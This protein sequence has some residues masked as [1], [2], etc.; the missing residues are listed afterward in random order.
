M[1]AGNTGCHEAFGSRGDA[2][3]DLLVC[4]DM[5]DRQIGVED[6]LACHEQG[7]LHRAFSVVLWR[8]GKE[9]AEI[10]LQQRAQGKYHSGGLWANAC[11]SHPRAG[12]ELSSAVRR[13]LS[14]ELGI[15]GVECQEIGSFVYY[16]PFGNGLS[17]YEYDHVFLGEYDGPI[18]PDAGEIEDVR[19]VD[20]AELGRELRE[21]PER[22]CAWFFSVAGIAFAWLSREGVL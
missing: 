14:Q 5:L 13:R 1:Q 7:L 19:W 2:A 6:K 10:L 16:A 12:E 22:F 18:A 17:E 15:E 11:C 3:E 20:A 21:D 9:G 8:K 4:V